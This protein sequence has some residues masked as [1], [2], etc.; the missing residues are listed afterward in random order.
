VIDAAESTTLESLTGRDREALTRLGTA[1]AVRAYLGGVLALVDAQKRA[2]A[3][4]ANRE[5]AWAIRNRL[6]HGDALLGLIT[7]GTHCDLNE[8]E[9]SYL[10]LPEFH[11]CGYASA[12]LSQ[13]CDRTFATR[14]V[15]R[16]VAETQRA[17]VPSTRLL[18][19][20]GFE[21][22]YDCERFHATQSVYALQAPQ[23][24]N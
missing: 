16:I 20:L 4:I 24:P 8:P 22:L 5:S 17:N 1:P 11:G 15:A 21:H 10:L 19:R 14:G 6:G 13:A 18:E 9:I 7:L 3:L 2:E 12:A 23:A